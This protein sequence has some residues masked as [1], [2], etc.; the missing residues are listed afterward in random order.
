[1]P[2]KLATYS[3]SLSLSLS[4]ARS[5]GHTLINKQSASTPLSWLGIGFSI[6]V[7]YVAPHGWCLTTSMATVFVHTASCTLVS[8]FPGVRRISCCR[9]VSVQA[10][11]IQ[12]CYLPP[13]RTLDICSL[14]RLNPSEEKEVLT[15]CHYLNA[16][17]TSL[18]Q[19]YSEDET[20]SLRDALL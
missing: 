6:F 11:P 12:E 13:N 4:H 8:L 3:L 9:E 7:F 5:H 18:R 1:M 16:H 14:S 19:L 17:S 15:E 20:K 2:F 10:A